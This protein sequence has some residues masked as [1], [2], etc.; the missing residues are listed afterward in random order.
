MDDDSLVRLE[1]FR[2]ISA[3][4]NQMQRNGEIR[5]YTV[6]EAGQKG[7]IYLVNCDGY[8]IVERFDAAAYC[9]SCGDTGAELEEFEGADGE[10][11]SLCE[12]CTGDQSL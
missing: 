1:V 5:G 9:Y 12:W 2:D 10:D 7:Y 6:A 8:S 4:L 3:E 11:F